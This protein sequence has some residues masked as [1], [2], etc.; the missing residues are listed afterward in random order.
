M[1]CA[2]YTKELLNGKTESGRVEGWV[3]RPGRDTHY[4]AY[5]DPRN[6][7]GKLGHETPD[8]DTMSKQKA[9]DSIKNV[10]LATKSMH[11]TI[12][13]SEG[14]T[15]SA[16]QIFMFH[17]ELEGVRASIS[18]KNHSRIWSPTE[19][20]GQF[21]TDGYKSSNAEDNDWSEAL[22]LYGES[23]T[24]TAPQASHAL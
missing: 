5:S 11:S 19:F 18:N 6:L 1:T 15:R 9:V 13:P 4:G 10:M 12:N 23:P 24:Q 14:V 22:L 20:L 3:D 16:D 21:D 2:D 8:M 17:D 7:R